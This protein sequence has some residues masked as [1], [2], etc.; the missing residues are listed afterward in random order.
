MIKRFIKKWN[1]IKREYRP[2]ILYFSKDLRRYNEKIQIRNPF[3]MNFNGYSV[4]DDYDE[5]VK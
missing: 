4:W 5:R 1:Q 3:F 2:D